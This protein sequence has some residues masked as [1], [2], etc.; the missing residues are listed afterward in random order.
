MKGV[1]FTFTVPKLIY[2]EILIHLRRCVRLRKDCK[3]STPLRK[4]RSAPKDS[5]QTAR[6]EQKLDGLVS[7][8]KARSRGTISAEE[9]ASSLSNSSSATL[10]SPQPGNDVT[11]HRNSYS[12]EAHSAASSFAY[13]LPAGV[14]PS[15]QDAQIWF[16]IFR[17]HY[18]R[19]VPFAVPYVQSTNSAQLR[20]EKPAFWLSIM[21]VTCP[22]I[23][24]QV[25]LGRGLKEIISR[26][27]IMNSARTIDLLMSILIFIHWYA[28]FCS[29]YY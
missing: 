6:L 10:T 21:A 28:V 13:P 15:P 7:L 1:F 23:K 4:K 27:I 14:E 8:L 22:V 12:N 24:R 20:V 11:S 16:R 2:V 18:L 3:P 5:S 29:V 25:S 26:E 9:I 17:D 19:H